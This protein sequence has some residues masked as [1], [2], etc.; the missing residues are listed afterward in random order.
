MEYVQNFKY[1]TP[2]S[3]WNS[4]C[5]P[6]LKIL[7]SSKFMLQLDQ[8]QK[9]YGPGGGYHFFAGRDATAAFVTGKFEGEG[10]TDDVSNLSPED[11]IGIEEWM[12][13]YEKDYTYVGKLEGRYYDR[14][15]NAT[16]ELLI[17]QEKIHEGHQV[18]KVESDD[19]TLYPM[20][21][22]AWTQK[23]GAT[24]WCTNKSGGKQ[25]DWTGVPRKYYK[26]GSSEYRC[27]CIRTTGPPGDDPTSAL[28]SGD[29]LNPMFKPYKNCHEHAI[30]CKVVDD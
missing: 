14:H 26:L 29:L 24:V 6:P 2:V 20:C 16:T 5:Q 7:K 28:S 11:M 18:K 30:T 22:S 3:F 12:T 4:R 27:A 1:E 17:A 25:R 21:N 19:K 10:L 9:H 23:D 8:S 15:G 13:F